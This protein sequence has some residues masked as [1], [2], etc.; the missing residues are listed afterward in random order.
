LKTPVALFIFRRPD[1]T[2]Q[3]FAEIAK[4]KPPQLLVVANAPRDDQEEEAKSRATR[5]I[6]ERVDWDCQVLKR[7]S[8]VHINIKEQ[9]GGG[10]SWVF[11]Q[12][13]DAI[14]L[15]DDC[16]PHQS[17]FPFCDEL[18]EKYRH[19][20]RVMMIAGLNYLGEWK[21]ELQ[22][23]HFSHMA[24][25]WGWASWRRAWQMFDLEM[26]WWP[27]VLESGFLEEFLPNPRYRRFWQNIFQLTYEGKLNTWDYQWFL[28]CWINHGLR[29]FPSVNLVTNIGAGPGATNKFEANPFVNM[30]SREMRFPLKHPAHMMPSYEADNIFLDMIADDRVSLISQLKAKAARTFKRS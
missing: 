28:D 2:A 30:P 25:T 8:G 12:V 24:G 11:D 26:K 22:S 23:Y 27:Y 17:F 18:L 16:V 6:I 19:D 3:V 9:I 13:E 7:Y 15:E 5:A 20:T 29:I 10:L 4:A 14:I 21:P 1:T